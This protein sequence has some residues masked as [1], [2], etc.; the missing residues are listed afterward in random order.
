MNSRR[1]TPRPAQSHTLRSSISG[2]RPDGVMEASRRAHRQH[3]TEPVPAV[4]RRFVFPPRW[5]ADQPVMLDV[6]SS[7]QKL[8]RPTRWPVEF[9]RFLFE[10][11]CTS[12]LR[13]RC[14]MFPEFSMQFFGVFEFL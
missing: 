11:D 10:M 14:K 5:S 12:G 8:S 1:S 4:S 9:Y 13:L 7:S 6:V 3:N 2:I